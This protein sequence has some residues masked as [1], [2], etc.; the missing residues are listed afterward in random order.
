MAARS[1]LEVRIQGRDE[2]SPQL[3]RLESKLIRFVGAVSAAMTAVSVVGFPVTAIRNFEKEMAN[4]QKTTG[5]TDNQIKQLGSSIVDLSRRINVVPEGLA[6]IAAAAGQ[7]GLGGQGVDG[8]LQ[9]TESVSRMSAV[10]DLTVEEAGANI[11]KIA[12]IFKI[13]LRDIENAVSSFNEVSNNSTATGEQLL[14]VVKRIGDAAGSLD[15]A[16]SIGVAATGI[17]LGLSPEVVGSSFQ[18]VFAEMYGRAEGF[19]K[20]LNVSVKDWMN[21]VQNDGI[22]A[23]KMYLDGLRKLTP[24]AQQQTIKTLSGGGRIGALVTKLLRDTEDEILD[25]NVGNAVNGIT[26]GTSAIKEQQTVLQTLDAEIQKAANSFQSLGIIAGDQ[27]AGQLA[28]Y[29]AQLNTALAD[30]SV[31]QFAEAVGQAF[32][33]M[34]SGIAS[35]IKLVAGLNINWQNFVQ[36]AKVLIGLKLVQVLG[37][38]VSTIPG[39]SAAWASV[40][41]SAQAAGVAQENASKAGNKNFAEA[42]RLATEYNARRKAINQTIKEEA[43]LKAQLAQNEAKQRAA[44]AAAE[45][46]RGSVLAAR[47]DLSEARR[48]VNTARE[49]VGAAETAA[50]ARREQVQRQLDARLER[51]AQEHAARLQVIEQR[52]VQAQNVA[53]EEG[54]R[55]A[56]LAATRARNAEVAAEEAHQARSL[57]SIQAYYARRLTAATAAGQAEVAAARLA[58]AQS[59]STF[60]GV[61]TNIG[62]DALEDQSRKAAAGLAVANANLEATNRSLSFA[63]RAT[64]AASAGFGFLATGARVAARALQGLVAIA[65]RVFFWFGL[66]YTALDAFGVLEKMGGYFEAFT[67]ALGFTSAAARREAERL[68]KETK[69]L[70]EDMR[71]LEEARA[72]LQSMRDSETGQISGAEEVKLRTGL[73]SD[74]VEQF[75]NSLQQLVDAQAGAYTELDNLDKTRGSFD[76]EKR[77]IEGQIA[78]VQ[79]GMVKLRE[80]VEL[81]QLLVDKARVPGTDMP[82]QYDGLLEANQKAFAEAEKDLARLQAQMDKVGESSGA[83]VD[84]A[85]ANAGRD[86]EKLQDYISKVFS[87]QSVDIFTSQYPEYVKRLQEFQQAQQDVRDAAQAASEAEAGD[88]ANTANDALDRA[89]KAQET[90]GSILAATKADILQAITELQQTGGLSE[91]VIG[92]LDTLRGFFNYTDTQLNALLK[93]VGNVQAAGTGFNPQYTAPKVKEDQGTGTGKSQTD[94]EL[95]RLRRARIDLARSELQSIANLEREANDQKQARDE[96]AYRQNLSSFSDYY[97]SRLAIQR[98]N[99]DIELRL[100]NDE[101]AAYRKELGEAKEESE[102]LRT[103]SL[104]VRAEGEIKVLQQQRAALAEQTDRELRDALREFNDRVTEQRRAL[105]DFFGASSEQEAFRSSLD[106]AQVGYRDF[107]DRLRVESANMPEL[108]PIIDSIELQG[109]FEAVS[110]GFS[111]VAR[112]ATISLGEIDLQA[113][114]IQ[115]LREAGMLTN[116]QAAVLEDRNRDAIIATQEAAIRAQ[117]ARLAAMVAEKGA[118]VLTTDA[119]RELAQE[120]EQ[121]KADVQDLRLQANEVARQINEDFRGSI[122]QLFI[123]LSSNEDIKTA[124]TDFFLNVL[125][126]LQ[127]T[128]AEELSQSFV[129]AIGSIGEGGLGGFFSGLAGEEAGLSDMV[130]K[131]PTSPMYIKDVD[132]ALGGAAGPGGLFGGAAAAVPGA[133]AVAG[134]TEAAQAAAA[135]ADKGF[136]A[137]SFDSLGQTF[138]QVGSG[139]TSMLG[140]VASTIVGGVSGGFGNL[141]AVLGTI[142]TSIVSAIFTA[143]AAEQTSGAVS[144]VGSFAAAHNGGVAGRTTMTRH[145]VNP[146]VFAHAVRHHNGNVASTGLAPNEVPAILERG[147]TVRTEAQEAALQA[148]LAAGSGGGA[149]A[150]P[151]PI[152]RVQ[153]VLSEETILEAMKGKQGEKLLLVHIQK[154]PNAFK[155]ALK[156]N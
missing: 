27:F 50:A 35:G 73:E 140:S 156:L 143:S 113:R 83:A 42:I 30:E 38:L 43:A 107:V 41:G 102:K 97:A 128:A 88:A 25:R 80:Q 78:G 17:D 86:A 94:A 32:L 69:A 7:Q 2:L 33:D 148:Q 132:A 151:E 54:N 8:I 123:D 133:P 31:I 14:D 76:G 142:V 104:I 61:A 58:F 131:T 49:A 46:A 119:Y 34:F 40:T 138:S 121:R 109:Y 135:V 22:N 115:R 6:A 52:R 90:A 63:Q 70:E 85:I 18:K 77:R 15:L 26:T 13:P 68:R 44:E 144:S 29:F 96:D 112:K 82:T 91:A 66:L 23:L 3:S 111:D 65:G 16:Q 45:Q 110:A 72:K 139:L 53:R 153:P 84:R 1:D 51:A 9:F 67:D 81:A 103:Q 145:N 134:G 130:G 47:V 141:I 5:F 10:L 124:F 4:V 48:P 150:A 100:Q 122:K 108:L 154:N 105:T 95:R 74:D 55:A 37:G 24:E 59:L 147:E 125:G 98:S 136:F 99:I 149:G 11:G 120:I 117:E 62:M 101:L 28:T 114:E 137:D 57:R 93:A 20:L 126:N 79:E 146:A 39:L 12:S 21:T 152:F 118:V 116:S 127:N 75:R 155:Q 89:T 19:S 129:R 64:A 36:I 87:D 92:S 71:R 60:D 106:A 56:L